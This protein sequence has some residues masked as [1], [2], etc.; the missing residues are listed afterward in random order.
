MNVLKVG[1]NTTV[2]FDDG[3]IISVPNCDEELFLDLVNN[4]YTYNQVLEKTCPGYI[5]TMELK[6]YIEEESNMLELRGNSV[7]MP[8]VSQLSIPEDFVQ[9]FVEAERCDDYDLMTTYKNFWT[10]VSLNPDSRV[11]NNLF[12]FIRKWGMKITKSGLIIAYRNADIKRQGKAFDVELTKFVTEER[13]RIKHVSKKSPKDYRVIKYND[14]Y[15]L[16][17]EGMLSS[18]GEEVGNLEELYQKIS[19]NEIDDVTV[20]TD[21]H[22]HTFTI[23]IGHIVKMKRDNVDS[24][25]EHSCSAGL[26][27]G[28]KGWLKH[29]YFGNVGLKVLVNPVHVCAVPTI[30]QYGKMRTCEY[31]PIGTI[32][33]DE[34]GNVVD[35]IATDGYED[36]YF[37]SICYNGQI[38]NEDNDNYVLEIPSIV[39]IDKEQAWENLRQIARSLRCHYE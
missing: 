20:F 1:G 29:N 38:N 30:D 14:D 11:R 4:E 13:E 31:L 7:I 27:V 37:Q 21:R 2:I 24:E 39:E 35:D 5:D 22:S 3:R 33:F 8:S 12:W 28:A 9:R 16:I 15:L 10:L 34:E 17:K 6:R 18:G 32:K 23:R 25:Q 36:E 19:K 26:H